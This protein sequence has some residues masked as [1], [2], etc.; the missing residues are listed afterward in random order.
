MAELRGDRRQRGGHHRAVGSSQEHRQDDRRHHQPE[1]LVPMR[2]IAG[3][4]LRDRLVVHGW[5]SSL[6]RRTPRP[7]TA[8]GPGSA[9]STGSPA[10]RWRGV[11]ARCRRRRLSAAGRTAMNDAPTLTDTPPLSGKAIAELAEQLNQLLKLRTF[12]IGMKL[13]EDVEEMEPRARA[14]PADQ[15]QDLLHLPAGHPVAHGRVHPGHHHGERAA[16]LQLLQRDRAGRAGGDL[17]LRPQDGGRVVR[18]PRGRRRAPGR[19]VARAAR[20]LPRAGDLAAAHRRGWTRR[21]SACSTAIRR[22]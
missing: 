15:G 21:I 5:R 3:L 1:Q 2:Q 9:G 4:R 22:R 7:V 16:V 11:V 17:H 14:A 18:E 6:V 10:S 20:A 13:F 8:P 19:H 12:P